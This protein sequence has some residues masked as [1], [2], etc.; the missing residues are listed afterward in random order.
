M[1][2]CCRC[3][4]TISRFLHSIGF[5]WCCLCMAHYSPHSLVLHTDT[6]W[7]ERTHTQPHT[8][9]RTQHHK[10]WQNISN[11]SAEKKWEATASAIKSQ[12]AGEPEWL[13][14]T[15]RPVSTRCTA[16]EIRATYF[17]FQAMR[18]TEW[19]QFGQIEKIR[20]NVHCECALEN[21][22]GPLSIRLRNHHWQKQTKKMKIIVMTCFRAKSIN[23]HR[24]S[25]THWH[26]LF[27][28][29]NTQFTHDERCE[30]EH[31]THL[32]CLTGIDFYANQRRK[33]ESTTFS[34]CIW[35]VAKTKSHVELL[36]T[37]Y[38]HICGA[39]AQF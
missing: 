7:A 29:I 21:W 38:R 19:M 8:R 39:N 10:Y 9:T 36:T 14:R 11:I 34:K 16:K 31:W 1:S 15:R 30:H 27:D 35:C 23:G 32:R 33:K 3:S 28:P 24:H 2:I 5:R 17:I 6:V 4:H 20:S 18:N 26:L 13:G 25:L 22:N 12:R 37:E